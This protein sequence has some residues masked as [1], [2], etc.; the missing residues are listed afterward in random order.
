[1]QKAELTLETPRLRMRQFQP[2]DL[3]EY[4]AMCADDEVMRHL[5]TGVT[6]SRADAWRSMAAILGHWQLLGY[7]MWALELKASR[8]LIGRAGYL[9]PPGWPAFEVGW[10]LARAHWGQ[11]YATEA[12]GRAMD[13]AFTRL[14]RDKVTSLIRPE[15]HRSIR[16]AERLG[17]MLAGEVQLLGA[18]ALVY[19]ARRP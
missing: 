10:V 5:G 1:M 8:Q 11:G 9:D 2:S 7:G 17:E 14:G 6:L 12:A 15:N 19:E 16:V 3:D 18:R 4:A 13:H